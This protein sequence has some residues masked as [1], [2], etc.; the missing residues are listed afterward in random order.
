LLGVVV[1]LR[2]ALTQVSAR[3]NM[4]GRQLVA[5]GWRSRMYSRRRTCVDASRLRLAGAWRH[6]I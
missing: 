6:W 5:L 4:C 2:L 3:W 1:G